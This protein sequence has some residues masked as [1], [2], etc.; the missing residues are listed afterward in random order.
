[1]PPWLITPSKPKLME[2]KS[3]SY[4]AIILGIIALIMSF[5]AIN[6]EDQQNTDDTLTRIQKTGEINVCTVVFP[7]VVI[8][9]AKTGEL[10][11]HFV[12]TMNIIAER[13]NA[14]VN[15]YEST[16]GNAAADLQSK[17]CDLVAANFFANI[18]RA[19]SVAFTKPPLFYIGDSALVR[20]NDLRFKNIKNVFD[21]DKPNI[22]IA[23]ATGEAGDIFVKEHFKNAKVTRIDV[24]SSDLARFAVEVS[25][26]RAD[27]AIA[28]ANT[29]NLYAKVHPEVIDLFE[30]N[31]FSLNPVGWAVRQDDVRWL[32]FIETALQFLD[33]QGTLEEL[34]KKYNAHWL[35]EIKQFKLK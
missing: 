9:N 30:N 19:A 35:H 27:V 33:T 13:I 22:T 5:T 18:P 3:S 32:H 17:H 34:E 24:E 2:Q 31:P 16:W 29:I 25:A 15:W 26:K 28:D 14:K 4:I 12:D 8:K 1:M 21:F 11:G 20:K 10:T 23:V 7:P 6:R